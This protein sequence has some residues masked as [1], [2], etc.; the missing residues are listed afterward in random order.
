MI[1]VIIPTLNERDNLAA[2]L[3]DLR[4]TE[5]E[6][7]IIIVDGGSHDGTQA[8]ATSRM[9]TL[10]ETEASRGHQLAAGV[11]VANADVILFLHADC[12]FPLFGLAEI[13][14]RLDEDPELIGG[15]FRLSFSNA[16]G[17]QDAFSEWLTGFY[18]FIRHFGLYYG[19]SGIFIRKSVLEN[20]GGIKPLAIMEDFDLIRRMGKTKG[21]TCNI[22]NLLLRTSSRRFQGRSFVRIF[23]GWLTMHL[24]YALGA[25][26]NRLAKFY[27]S[28]RK[29]ETSVR[30]N[31]IEYVSTTT[32]PHK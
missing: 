3:S 12:R 15:N 29:V 10:I 32:P 28:E 30:K 24:M 31:T 20:I 25:S 18:S 4:Q 21:H 17:V 5:V 2:L 6:H 16:S 11:G 9:L 22:D 23:S 7:E 14:R 8:I 13:K 1:S 27:D 26:G 19:D